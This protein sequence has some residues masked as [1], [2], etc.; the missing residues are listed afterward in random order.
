MPS[1][2]TQIWGHGEWIVD[3]IKGGEER[4]GWRDRA[5]NKVEELQ[6]MEVRF[7][8]SFPKKRLFLVCLMAT[9]WERLGIV[10][11]MVCGGCVTCVAVWVLVVWVKGKWTKMRH[12]PRVRLGGL[13]KCVKEGSSSTKNNQNWS[14]MTLIPYKR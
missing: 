10:R 14:F 3:G 7:Y 4:V 9:M 11:V 1:D 2:E 5:I 13:I 6:P 8:L 12:W